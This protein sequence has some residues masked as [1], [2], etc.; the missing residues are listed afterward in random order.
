M[1][2]KPFLKKYLVI[3][4]GQFLVAACGIFIA[5]C[6]IFIAACGIFSCRLHA[7]S[8]SLTRDWTRAPF[9]GSKEFFLVSFCFCFG[10]VGSSLLCAGFLQLQWAGATLRCGVRASHCSGFSCCRAW[11]LGTR[12]SVVATRGLSSFGLQVLECRLGSCGT[13]A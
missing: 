13:W 12:A 6:G 4:L 1:H 7:R 5:T 9:V 2:L 8:S 3:W 10:C 11:A